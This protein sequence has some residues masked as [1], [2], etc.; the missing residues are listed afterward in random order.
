MEYPVST[1]L[2]LAFDHTYQR[3]VTEQIKTIADCGFRHMDFNF[4][5]WSVDP[6]SGF[7]TDDWERWT[8]QAGQFAEREGIVFDQ[9]HAAVVENMIYQGISEQM[10]HE[11]WRRAILACQRLRIPWLVFHCLESADENWM[12]RNHQLLDPYVELAQKAGVGIAFEN[13]WICK[14][15][16]PFSNTEALIEFVDSFQDP[17]VGICFDTGHA[18]VHKGDA[19]AKLASDP[20]RQLTMIGHRLKALH[21]NDNNGY[22]DDHIAPFDGNVCWDAVMRGLRDAQYQG[23]FTFETHNAVV[24]LPESLKEDKIRFLKRIG[25]ELVRG[26]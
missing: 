2:N 1:S 5:D 17:L 22:G 20:Y 8:D 13:I 16:I 25:E 15:E 4:L 23:A 26:F 19:Q 10:L 14:K 11:Q 18:N 3:D 21:I 7:T 24:R 12:E 9:A 6:R